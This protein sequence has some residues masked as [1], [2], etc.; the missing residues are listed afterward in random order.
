MSGYSKFLA[1]KGYYYT[2]GAPIWAKTV[3]LSSCMHTNKRADKSII[4]IFPKKKITFLIGQRFLLLNI[5][6]LDSSSSLSR[7]KYLKLW[8]GIF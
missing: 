6:D 3:F 5:S 4:Q 8:N 2:I 1:I 7:M